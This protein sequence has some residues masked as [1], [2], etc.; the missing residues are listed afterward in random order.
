M[1]KRKPPHRHARPADPKDFQGRPA[2]SDPGA[3]RGPSDGSTWIYGTHAAL[4]ALANPRRRCGRIVVL[5]ETKATLAPMLEK[6][7]R[8]GG[9]WPPI[10]TVARPELDRLLPHGAVHQGL[11]VRA[12]PLAPVFIEEIVDAAGA[13]TVVVLDQTTDPQNVG[14]VLRAAA[15]FGVRAVIVQDRH[16]PPATGALAKAASGALEL[17]SL[18]RVTNLARAMRQLKD[19]EFWC[20]GLDAEAATGLPD[21]KLGGRT[22]LVLGAEGAGLR[23][24]TRETCDL[25][26]RIPIRPAMESLNVAAAAAVALYEIARGTKAGA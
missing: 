3:D 25:L 24:L 2:H 12:Q 18:V 9:T 6:A 21:A 10:E 11:A 26:V 22:A 7:F 8:Q 17:V 13:A 20:V 16:T 15:A 5:A 14:A 23:R 1:R 4:A 19:A